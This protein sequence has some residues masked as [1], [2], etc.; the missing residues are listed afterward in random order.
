MQGTRYAR[1]RMP[2]L[3]GMWVN[4]TSRDAPK[5]TGW[6]HALRW[7]RVGPAREK[8]EKGGKNHAPLHDAVR[9]HPGGL[10][11]PRR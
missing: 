7:K 11:D 1:P 6:H 3:L 5:L 10:G 4:R 8:R 9:L 2:L